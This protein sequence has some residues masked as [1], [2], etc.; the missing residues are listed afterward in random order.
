MGSSRWRGVRR[1][2]PTYRQAPPILHLQST[3]TAF[4]FLLLLHHF[5]ISFW[6]GLYSHSMDD[7]PVPPYFTLTYFVYLFQWSFLSFFFFIHSIRGAYL[8]RRSWTGAHSSIRLE[9]IRRRLLGLHLHSLI[10]ISFP[11][12]SFFPWPFMTKRLMIAV[13]FLHLFFFQ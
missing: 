7:R 4:P 11:N 5:V 10:H 9:D 8:E 2:Q 3:T 6:H 1:E 12:L 13:D